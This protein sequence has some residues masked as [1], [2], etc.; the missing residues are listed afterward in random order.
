M[1]IYTQILS[2]PHYFSIDCSL[3]S[4]VATRWR[5]SVIVNKGTPLSSC[6]CVQ[7]YQIGSLKLARVGVFTPRKP[8]NTANHGFI[9]CFVH[10]LRK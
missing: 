3:P 6:V 5:Y 2:L 10:C 1:V 9:F 8:T 7:R 4:P